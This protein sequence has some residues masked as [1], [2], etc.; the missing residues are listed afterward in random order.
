[1]AT[2]TMRYPDRRRNR[3]RFTLVGIESAAT[4]H[5]TE[6]LSCYVQGHAG[7]L[8]LWGTTGGENRHISEVNQRNGRLTVT[9]D[10]AAPDDHH[11]EKY[12][13]RYWVD[14]DDYFATID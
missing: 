12:G 7:L 6:R 13:H 10:W 5:G 9:C 11:A 3:S 4:G 8:V 2:L 1:M 14:E